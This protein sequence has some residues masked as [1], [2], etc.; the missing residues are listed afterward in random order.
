MPKNKA[1]GEC[2]DFIKNTYV[3]IGKKYMVRKE[4]VCVYCEK[5]ELLSK[6]LPKKEEYPDL[7][8]FFSS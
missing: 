5:K 8:K 4:K 6:H 7:G 1:C 3:R 2:G